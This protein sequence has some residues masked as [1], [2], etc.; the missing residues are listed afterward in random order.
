MRG[1]SAVTFL[2]E[3]NSVDTV[4][5]LPN[6]LNPA[7]YY[8]PGNDFNFWVDQN[9]APVDEIRGDVT[10]SAVRGFITGGTLTID[11]E[12][13]WTIASNSETFSIT[14]NLKK[15]DLLKNATSLTFANNKGLKIK[16]DQATLAKMIENDGNVLIASYN[17]STNNSAVS[18]AVAGAPHSFIAPL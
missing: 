5:F 13:N 9:G 14:I 8:H 1:L 2:N 12:G 7:K 18:S 17:F 10:L 15:F 4:M 3:D 16:L 11:E 6:G